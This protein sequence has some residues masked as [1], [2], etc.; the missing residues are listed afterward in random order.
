MGLEKAQWPVELFSFKEKLL[1]LE[2]ITNEYFI[3]TASNPHKESQAI[4]IDI[5]LQWENEISKIEIEI[6]TKS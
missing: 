2:R 4:S 5:L 3:Q 1:K 6:E